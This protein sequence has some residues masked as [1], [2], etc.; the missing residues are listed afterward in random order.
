MLYTKFQP[1]IPSHSGEK[2]IWF[3]YFK[4]REPPWILDL[5]EFYLSE[6]IQSGHAACEI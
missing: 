1:N 4:H 2:M 3:C 6:A 5:A